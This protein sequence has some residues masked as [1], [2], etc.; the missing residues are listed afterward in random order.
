M[1]VDVFLLIL[2]A[3]KEGH[4][5]VEQYL[6]RSFFISDTV[7]N[8]MMIAYN[9]ISG[10]FLGKRLL[11]VILLPVLLISCLNEELCED[12]ETVPVRIGFYAVIENE[13]EPV[14]LIVDSLKVHGLGK[15]SLIYNYQRNI[16][17]IELP[18][19]SSADS[20][21][22]ILYFPAPPEFSHLAKD[23]IWFYYEVLPT[24]ISMECG[25][26]SFF[27]LKEVKHSRMF[28]DSIFIEEV[29]VTN[30]LDEHIKIFPFIDDGDN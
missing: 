4:C 23:T 26:V 15:D 13:E 18:L 8:T 27:E 28:I 10:L 3:G 24:L 14:N 22:F 17:R 30:I 12:V 25:F 6:N 19:N 20:S 2:A 7:M 9:Y 5:L 29:S 1:Q 11:L 21:A 16:S